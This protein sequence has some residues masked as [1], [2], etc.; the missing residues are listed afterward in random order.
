MFSMS[1]KEWNF[2]LYERDKV[3]HKDWLECPACSE[4]QHSCHVDGNAKLY[5]YKRGKYEKCFL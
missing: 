1:F 5:R 4:T 3:Q 2:W